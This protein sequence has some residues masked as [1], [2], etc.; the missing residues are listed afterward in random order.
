MLIGRVHVISNGFTLASLIFNSIKYFPFT[1]DSLKK[2]DI[3]RR[4]KIMSHVVFTLHYN[5]FTLG[6]TTQATLV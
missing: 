6:P 2:W 1:F 5:V 4:C 3:S